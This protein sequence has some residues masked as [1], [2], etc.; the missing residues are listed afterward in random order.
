MRFS[1]YVKMKFLAFV[2]LCVTTSAHDISQLK[3][4]LYADPRRAAELSCHFKMDEQKLHSV[5]WYRDTNEI[6]R[7]NPTQ[8]PSIRL[9]NISDVM[10]QG[11]ECQPD[12]CVVRVMPP[13]ISTR[14]AYTCEVSTE[15]P[16]FQIARKTKHMTVVAMP[17]AD[18]VIIGAPKVLKPGEQ[19]F[20]NC[21][22]DFSLPPSDINWYIDEE[23]QKPEPWQKTEVTGHQPGGL[24]RSWRVMR[25]RVPTTAS[26]AL[27]VRCESILLV[28]PPVVRDA[29]T[30]ITIHSRTQ[31]SKYVSNISGTN[32]VNTGLLI[33]TIVLWTF[34]K[35]SRL[36]SL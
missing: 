16:R 10:V 1:D 13:P 30:I 2:A 31:L 34:I 9:F 21:T 28:E 15:G 23:L 17:Q 22:S 11:G 29:N 24:R 14:A 32:V 26:G 36:T 5:K 20:L 4:P 8:Q 35:I 7:Y 19:V 3:V 33:A 6:F 12:Y 18:P 25:V 27:R